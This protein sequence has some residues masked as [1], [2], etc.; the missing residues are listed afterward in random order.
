MSDRFPDSQHNYSIYE[1]TEIADGPPRVT[2]YDRDEKTGRLKRP[3]VQVEANLLNEA[4]DSFRMPVRLNFLAYWH[5]EQ[6]SPMTLPKNLIRFS[7]LAQ[8]EDSIPWRV[9]GEYNPDGPLDHKGWFRHAR[10]KPGV[11]IVRLDDPDV[12][13]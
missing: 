11:K 6:R 8:I 13:L 2:V 12:E 1:K 5:P 4:G 9:D 10:P 3:T 7:A